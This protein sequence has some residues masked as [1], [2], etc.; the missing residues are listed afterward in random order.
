M[1]SAIYQYV[2]QLIHHN[3]S[4]KKWREFAIL[5]SLGERGYC[6]MDIVATG[7]EGVN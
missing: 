2:L 3:F 4:N 5:G 1:P 7:Y 6:S